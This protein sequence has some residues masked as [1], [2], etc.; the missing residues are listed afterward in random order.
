VRELSSTLIRLS[1]DELVAAIEDAPRQIG[2]A[3]DLSCS[4]LVEFSETG[5]SI[6]SAHHWPRPATSAADNDDVPLLQRLI[7]R[8]PFDEGGIVLERI[9]EDLPVEARTADIIE[10]VGLMP[11]TSVVIIPIT[12][13]GRRTSVWAV[14]TRRFTVHSETTI[15][16][17]RLLAQ[18]IGSALYRRRQEQTLRESR[19]D[20]IRL[21]AQLDIESVQVDDMPSLHG[22]DEI[23][24]TS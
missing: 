9:P 19:A 15:E 21:T 7:E 5:S 1:G 23:I 11:L 4:T 22:F 10:R 13:A 18:I 6:E 12:I 14:G 8:L 20:M 17:L 24:G 2:E 3:L 16:R